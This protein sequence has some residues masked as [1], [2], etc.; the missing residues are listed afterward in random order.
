MAKFLFSAGERNLSAVLHEADVRA[1]FEWRTLLGL[2]GSWIAEYFGISEA[3]VS[4]I[5]HGKTWKHLNLPVLSFEQMRIADFWRCVDKRGVDEC[6]PWLGK[7]FRDT[8]YGSFNWKGKLTTAHRVSYTLHKGDIPTDKLVLHTCDNR[9]CVNPNHLF[10]GTPQDNVDD[11]MRK[12][13]QNFVGFRDRNQNGEKNNM[14]KLT[15]Q[16]V[17]AIRTAKKAGARVTDLANAYAVW[18]AAISR[19]C[20]GIRWRHSYANA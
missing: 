11:M 12:G 15:E 2:D 13:R 16:Q 1:I 7:G 14:V 19:I 10:A 5:I 17:H 18:P 8:S 3:Q 20:N 9:R 6:W 4:S